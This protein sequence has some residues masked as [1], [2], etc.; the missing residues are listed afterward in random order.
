[1][2]RRVAWLLVAIGTFGQAL[3]ALAQTRTGREVYQFAC[4]A[5]HGSDGSGAP[6]VDSGYPLVPP[7]FRE[8]GVVAGVIVVLATHALGL[9]APFAA[10]LGVR[11]AVALNLALTA[12]SRWAYR[13]WRQIYP[14]VSPTP[15]TVR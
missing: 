15:E 5:C 12:Y 6:A 13:R 8:I 10:A 7:D 1:M 14:P 9:Q 2:N 3:D 11:T 4:A